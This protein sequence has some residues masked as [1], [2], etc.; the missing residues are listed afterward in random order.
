MTKQE[1][2]IQSHNHSFSWSGTHSHGITD[3]GHSHKNVVDG[4]SE[5]S[6][7]YNKIATGSNWEETLSWWTEKSG[8]DISINSET[9]SIS[10]PTGFAGGNETRPAN[11]TI[12]IWK[13]TA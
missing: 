9:I 13:R 5:K 7:G 8:T 2:S 11:F 10:E 12:K 3:P 1:Q 4:C 6:Y